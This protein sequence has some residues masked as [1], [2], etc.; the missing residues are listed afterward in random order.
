M[1]KKL[2]D[3]LRGLWKTS[4]T[5]IIGIEVPHGADYSWYISTCEKYRLKPS[6]FYKKDYLQHAH[7]ICEVLH[8]LE[9]EKNQ[10]VTNVQRQTNKVVNYAM[11]R[12]KHNI[13]AD[14]WIRSSNI[15]EM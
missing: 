5:R 1:I 8:K 12:C 10:A 14:I 15:G 11:V 13:K 4:K 3:W 2:L 6:P 9:W 7:Y